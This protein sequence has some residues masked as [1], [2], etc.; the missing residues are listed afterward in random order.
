MLMAENNLQ[1]SLDFEVAV[2]ELPAVKVQSAR[3]GTQPLAASEPDL[4]LSLNV[5]G[6][7]AELLAVAKKYG[8]P[9]DIRDAIWRLEQIKANFTARTSSIPRVLMVIA[10]AVSEKS[11][12][13]LRKAGFGYWDQG[14]SLYIEL[15]WALFF[16]DRP[17][18]DTAPRRIRKPYSGQNAQVLHALLAEPGR[19]WQ[20]LDLAERAQTSTTTVHRVLTFLEQ[21]L[22][23]EKRG[24]GSATVRTLLDPGALLD[25]WAGN[26]SLD[27]YRFY[28]FYHWSQSRTVLRRQVTGTLNEMGIDYALT[29]DSGA[30]LVAPFTTGVARLAI[31]VQDEARI[32]QVAGEMNLAP[33]ESGE[34]IAFLA[35]RDY[36]PL[37]FRQQIDGANVASNVHLYLDLRAWPKRGKEQAEHLRSERLPY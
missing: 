34:N 31:L 33:V 12:E 25:A 20:I 13:I 24:K 1:L 4:C 17:R 19:D 10:P 15:P 30:E 35:T 11:R 22:W 6:E 29:L 21:Q 23:V 32:E 26:H 7:P 8:H 18:P 16:I 2:R 3:Y 27:K 14:G 5:Q 36:S 28:R 9:R 37:M